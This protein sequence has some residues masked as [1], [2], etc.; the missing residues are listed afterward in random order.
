MSIAYADILG[1]VNIQTGTLAELERAFK[2]YG[3]PLVKC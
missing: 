3:D 2:A 1:D